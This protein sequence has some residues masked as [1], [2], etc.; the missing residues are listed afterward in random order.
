MN[1]PVLADERRPA[2]VLADYTTIRT[3]SVA[4]VFANSRRNFPQV[5]RFDP[6]E[7]GGRFELH[8]RTFAFD[9]V[10]LIAAASTGHRISLVDNA[11]VGVL[12]PLVG[13]VAVDDG[14]RTAEVGAGGMLMPGVGAR[15]T[16]VG[17]DYD[18]LVLLVPRAA[19]ETRLEGDLPTGAAAPFEGV[20]ALDPT[21]AAAASLADYV[22]FLVRL[23]DRGGPIVADA[24]MQRSAA[25]LLGDLVVAAA[26]E[27]GE[28]A[29]QLRIA[30][31]AGAWQVA[32]A[33]AYIRAHAADVVSVVEV[34]AAVGTSIR[35]LQAAFHRHRGTTPRAYLQARRLDLL[36]HQLLRAAPATR[37]TEIA[38][39]CGIAHMG[40]CAAAYRQ[41]FGET[42]SETR[43][44]ALR[45]A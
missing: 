8:S 9:D 40:R 11:R 7:G 28:A 30:P 41:R 19:I 5:M 39:D 20:G 31:A 27:R 15:T 29:G 38:L 43:A 45:K 37:I 33:E 18:G 13:R 23:I 22:H 26:I 32:R 24:Q 42:P 12:M 44:R 10:K 4:T 36:H 34:A 1:T 21:A 25:A 3:S 2:R 14:R 17:R 6:L 16:T 35:A